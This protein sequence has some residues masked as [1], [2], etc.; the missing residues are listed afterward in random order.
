MNRSL[1]QDEA[2]RVLASAITAHQSG[3][4][5]EAAALYQAVL[6]RNPRDAYAYYL[7]GAVQ[8]EMGQPQAALS[9]LEKSVTIKPADQP[10][11][12]LLGAVYAAL[13][14]HEEAVVCFRK[15]AAAAPAAADAH[16]NLGKAEAAVQRHDAAAAA[17]R[18]ALRLRPSYPEALIGLATA[19]DAGGDKQGAVNVFLDCI[20]QFPNQSAAYVSLAQTY[21]AL[22]NEARAEEALKSCL[23]RF[24][25]KAEAILLMG[26]LRYR[27]VRLAE[28]EAY[29]LR[30]IPLAPRDAL[31]HAYLSGVLLNLNKLDAAEASAREAY[32]IDPGNAEVLTNLG[33]VLQARG[34]T[35]EAITFQRRAVGA[36]PQMPEAWNNLGIALQHQGEFA[37]ALSCYERAVTL[38]PQF[39]GALTNT[40]HALLVL[41]RLRE[42]WKNYINRFDQ[43]IMAS[44]RRD[45]P[46]PKWTPDAGSEARLLLWTDQGL[47]D[48]VLYASMLPDILGRVGSCTL[49]CSRRMVPL[50]QRSFPRLNVVPRTTPPQ[51][52][53]AEAEPTHQLSLIELGE[54]FRP[55]LESIPP[56]RGYLKADPDLTQA[57]RTKYQAL[58]QGRRIVGLS[59]RSENPFTGQFKSVDLGQWTPVLTAP[60]TLFVSLQYGDTGEEI[61]TV[62]KTIGIDIL[63]DPD[64]DA[65]QDPDRSAAQIAAMD[66]VISTSNT[67]VH[68][69]GAMNVPAWV[70]V[71]TGPGSLWYWFTVRHDSPWYPSVRLFR[72]SRA[73][74][75]S[76]VIAAIV[77]SLKEGARS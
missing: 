56:H 46:Y 20:A 43:K 59:W 19:L 15:V 32:R 28:A 55:T 1:Q 65:L 3:R 25:D 64:I 41:G 12:A 57:L 44:K 61:A 4:R 22:G 47:G 5:P 54:V 50:F 74:Q 35:A 62:S 45:F 29:F 67:T 8:Y 63:R 66:L 27:Q 68:F 16:A 75:W 42:G 48:E 31:P 11:T 10:T 7:L 18:T 36:N 69:A 14:R 34:A 9:A 24:P 53:I 70:L 58:A 33:L 76:D 38:K 71:P 26:I 37:E 52:A 72:Q 40:A 39:H 23:L 60:N 77:Q 73:G 6:E 51:A 30:V 49:E 2:K 21:M 17:F 13:Q